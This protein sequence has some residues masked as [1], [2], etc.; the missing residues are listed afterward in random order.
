MSRN[1]KLLIGLII[2][3]TIAFYVM[4]VI[5]PT[6]LA[7]RGYEAA[8]TLGEDFKKAF[9]FTP[10]ITVNN[11]VVLNQQ[12]PILEL[13]VL[14]Q[15][16]EHRYT[17]TNT[18]LNS[19]KQIFIS[20]TFEAK[21]GFDLNQKF[22]IVLNDDKAIVNLPEPQI[23]S[24]ESKG[25]ITYRDENGIWNWINTDD[26]TKATNAFIQDARTYATHAEFVKDA[27][28]HMEKRLRSLLQPYAKEV[29]IEYTITLPRKR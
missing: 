19:T 3:A 16:F 2:V 24:I 12:A 13:A 10:E 5:I 14:T 18:W 22:S 4:L 7:E 20:G 6:Q 26:R 1:L 29:V 23:L 15:N 27:K 11:T 21:A 25:D 8:R 9:Q 28:E 17:W